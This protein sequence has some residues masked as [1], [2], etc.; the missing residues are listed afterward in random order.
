MAIGILPRSNDITLALC[1]FSDRCDDFVTGSW[2]RE[3][4]SVN[5][6]NVTRVT[7]GLGMNG[8]A[9]TLVTAAYKYPL[10]T[11]SPNL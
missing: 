2:D 9:E 5:K 4:V 3:R 6:A 10:H 8:P 7:N 11:S 1:R